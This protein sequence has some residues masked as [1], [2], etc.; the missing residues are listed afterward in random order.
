MWK[1]HFLSIT[2]S[3]RSAFYILVGRWGTTVAPWSLW[4]AHYLLT[5]NMSAT[6]QLTFT[7]SNHYM[8]CFWDVSH[9]N[10]QLFLLSQALCT[11]GSQALPA[12]WEETHF[13]KKPFCHGDRILKCS[14][15]QSSSFELKWSNLNNDS[16]TGDH[17]SSFFFNLDFRF[18]ENR[19]EVLGV[20]PL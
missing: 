3:F 19:E 8:R 6:S 14:M 9:D 17:I 7:T 5:A 15:W 18:F 10:T 4:T 1:K 12:W 16:I 13:Y 2:V 11:W 20:D